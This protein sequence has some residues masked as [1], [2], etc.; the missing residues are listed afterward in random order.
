MGGRL[1][2]TRDYVVSIGDGPWL[3]NKLSKV[4]RVHVWQNYNEKT[5]FH[6]QLF[7]G[8]ILSYKESP[9]FWH[10]ISQLRTTLYWNHIVPD[11]QGSAVRKIRNHWISPTLVFRQK[12]I[13]AKGRIEI[14][15]KSFGL[16]YKLALDIHGQNRIVDLD[17][18][19]DAHYP[20][21]GHTKC[22]HQSKY[23]WI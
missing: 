4:W 21:N 1:L 20:N 6:V 15:V 8:L 2:P 10:V 9:K 3:L 22:M 19:L 14:N 11:R 5:S 23:R 16:F 12:N 13:R 18:N 7:I 17:F